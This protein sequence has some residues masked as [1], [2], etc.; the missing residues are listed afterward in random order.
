[1][2]SL[3]LA[4]TDDTRKLI[5][6]EFFD[7]LPPGAIVVNTAR[8]S[9][10]D[11][12]ALRAAIENKRLRVA[13]DVWCRQPKAGETHFADP[14]IQ[15]PGVI[16]THHN[17]ASTEQAQQAIA[18]ETVRI[19]RHWVERGVVP[20]A[21][22]RAERTPAKCLLTVRHL[23]QPGVLAAV[24]QLIGRA[25]I[26][27]EEMENVIYEGGR[28]ASARIFLDAPLP[29]AAL[30]ELGAHEHVLSAQQSSIAG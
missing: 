22:N 20:N 18:D 2:V 27:V 12:D 13:A 16:G 11:E 17:G 19:V 3:H 5:G 7:A 21:V 24:F 8:G 10:I 25:S 30:G 14:L 29:A 4:A 28:A 9:V 1:M 6:R 23:N 15:L 26:N